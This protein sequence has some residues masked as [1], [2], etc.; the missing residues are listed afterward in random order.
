MSQ[1]LRENR[2]LC[3]C[4]SGCFNSCFPPFGG[5]MGEFTCTFHMSFIYYNTK[6]IQVTHVPQ[7]GTEPPFMLPSSHLCHYTPWSKS[8]GSKHSLGFQFF[9]HAFSSCLISFSFSA[10]F[11]SVSF[12]L[13][14][15]TVR[16][17]YVQFPIFSSLGKFRPWENCSFSRHYI[18]QHC[19]FSSFYLQCGA[20]T[21]RLLYPTFF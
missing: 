4:L 9:L 2:T 18:S 13:C 3:Q 16:V 20:L 14:P 1:F 17:V 21:S 11:S 10:P 6:R 15:L 5:P 8:Y 7:L 19:R 12:C